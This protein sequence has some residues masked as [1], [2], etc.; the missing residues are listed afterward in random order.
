MNF[1]QLPHHVQERILRDNPD[2]IDRVRRV[3][4]RQPQPP[5]APPL[6]RRRPQQPRG[7]DGV[8]VRVV[9]V[10]LLRRPMDSDNLIGAIKPLR[11][12]V[13]ESL[14]LD[15]G[16]TRIAFEYAQA[17]T[18]GQEGVIVKVDATLI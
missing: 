17:H 10:V 6:D 2:L 16:D 8:V 12:A 4:T 1:D 13:C 9:F 5:V 15:D 18:A 7:P 14:G 3:E 11:D